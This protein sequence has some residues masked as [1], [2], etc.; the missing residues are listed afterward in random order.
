MN[1]ANTYG[2]GGS[3]LLRSLFL[4]LFVTSCSNYPSTISPIGDFVLEPYLGRWYEIARLD[5]RFERG[6]SNV[7]AEYS[8]NDDGS[9]RV[10]NRGFSAADNQWK[11][12]V[13]RARPVEPGKGFLK[14]SFFGPFYASYVIWALADDGSFAYISG[15]NN[16]YL[17]LLAR[18]PRV[19]EEVY[20]EFVRRSREAGYPVDE[21][22]LVDHSSR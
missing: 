1:N 8:L 16:S 14:V 5:H 19:D 3:R 7:T 4:C 11:E 12:A 17:W 21:L 9:V 6:L 13:G 20:R 18:E 2:P 15:P 22:I 10:V